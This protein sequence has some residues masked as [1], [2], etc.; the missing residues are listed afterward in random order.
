MSTPFL[1]VGGPGSNEVL[2]L[3]IRQTR[4]PT[5][6]DK[7]SPSGAPYQPGQVW[8]N[9][10]SSA[11]YM[12]TTG[13]TWVATGGS[14]T[15]VNTLSGDSGG[16]LSPTSGNIVIAGGTNVTT[17]GSGSTITVNLDATLTGLTKLNVTTGSNASIGTSAA[18]VAGTVTVSTTAVTASSIIFVS[19]N[20]AGGTT[21]NL[22]APTASIVAGTSFVIN[23][24]SNTDTST[25]NWWIIN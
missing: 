22:S 19:R 18:M 23:S 5:S 15:D 4:A 7:V 16:N 25:V 1:C 14:T 11:V 20:T 10:T 24:S 17:V 12:Y 3:P 2:P 9:V 13:G 8:V 6:N 21:G